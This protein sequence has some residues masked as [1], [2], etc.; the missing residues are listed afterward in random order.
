MITRMT[1]DR[2]DFE[3]NLAAAA[4]DDGGLR[5]ELLASFAS[6]LDHQIDLLRRARCG[7]LSRSAA[8]GFAVSHPASSGQASRRKSC[9]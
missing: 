4:G 8:A 2:A 9:V 5:A 7:G 6:S 3:A 1:M